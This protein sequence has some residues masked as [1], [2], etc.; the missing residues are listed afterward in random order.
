MFGGVAHASGQVGVV[1]DTAREPTAAQAIGR[2]ATATGPVTVIRASGVV[3][4]ADV[5]ALLFRGDTLET[6]ADGAIGIAFDDGSAF[7][8]AA[9]TRVVLDEFVY[10]PEGASSSALFSVVRGAFAFIAGKVAKAG[11]F[12][13]DTPVARICGGVQGRGFGTLTLAAL[14]FSIVE[15]LQAAGRPSE[16]LDYGAIDVGRF[17]IWTKEL[18]PQEIVVNDPFGTYVLTPQGDTFE[19]EFI[20]HSSSQMADAAAA[21]LRAFSIF[22]MGFGP[23]PQNVTGDGGSG[24]SLSTPFTF[25]PD[26]SPISIVTPTTTVLPPPLPPIFIPPPPDIVVIP[27]PTTIPPPPA[28]APSAV[29][30][31]SASD[32]FGPNGTSIDNITNDATPTVTGSGA[33]PG[34]LVT[35][36]DT[37]GTTVLGTDTA[38]AAGNWTITSSLL[39]AGDHT[40]TV[41]QTLAGTTSPPS[42]GLVVSIDTTAAAPS[43]PDLVA[44]SDL[45]APPGTDADNIT[46]DT[47]PTVTGGGAEPGALVTLYDTD[48]T[49]VLGTDTADAAGNWTITSSPLTSGDHTLTVKQ[50]D[51]AGNTSTAS[52]GL[53]VTVDAL[54]PTASIVVADAALQ[55]GETSLV[56]FTFS[57]AV[58]G[59]TNADLTIENGTLTDV[60]SSDGGV[61]WTATLTPAVDTTDAT[62]LITLDN[63]GVL[64]AAGNA[65]VG[66]TSSNNYAIDAAN[67]TVTDVTAND[68]V[69]SDLD[70][71]ADSFSIAVTFSEAMSTSATPVLTFAPDV[72]STLTLTG[73]VW[74]LGNTVYTATYDVAD[75]NVLVPSVTVDVEGAQ[76]ANGNAQVAYTAAVEF[77]IDTAN[78]TVVSVDAS[79][80]LITDADTGSASFSVTVVFNQ[81]MTADGSADPTLTFAPAVASTLSN[82]S[83]SWSPDGTTY[84]ATYDVADGDVNL[85]DVTVDVE[86]AQDANG[87]AQVAYTPL[88]EFSIDTLNPTVVS[89]DASDGLIT[90]ADTGLASFSVT[91][92]FNQAMTADGSAD[93]TLTFAPAVASTLSNLSGSVEPGRHD[94]HGDL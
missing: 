54:G 6:G 58:S 23:A 33:E 90:D 78:P 67:P 35:L 84:T 82:L 26:A 8:L 66:S 15:E 56:T 62:N 42:A 20:K 43:G 57:E 36:Y 41:T 39:T 14:T 80:G 53:L 77:A 48:G 75:A 92:V 9:G 76:D 89:V 65:G 86:G 51:I 16:F 2:I 64:D 10:E 19:V 72:A 74:S 18:V 61:T 1:A 94:L 71:V 30:L 31:N 21:A 25:P 12:G 60:S 24:N 91:V 44:A 32:S 5:G 93:P 59:F 37:D 85:A 17:T 7:E 27:E 81:A 45:F 50:T 13:I 69:I 88:A 79:D 46:N 38:D 3:G 34:A 4:R 55:A 11:N 22:G 87:N 40:L 73:G 49:T 52:A 63:T 29:D 83:G 70:A 47:T 28:N 68:P